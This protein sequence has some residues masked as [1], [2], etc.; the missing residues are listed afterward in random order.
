MQ[1]TESKEPQKTVVVT[2]CSFGKGVVSV[3]CIS[4]AGS[5]V[6]PRSSTSFL[7]TTACPFVYERKFFGDLHIRVRR[8]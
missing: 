7:T 8:C 5:A 1:N 4:V 6:E 2:Q 3:D